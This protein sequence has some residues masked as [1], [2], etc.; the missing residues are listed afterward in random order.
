MLLRML[1]HYGITGEP[2]VGAKDRGLVID[3]VCALILLFLPCVC[4]WWSLIISLLFIRTLAYVC[5][6]VSLCRISSSIYFCIY[7]LLHMPW[8]ID[9]PLLVT[10]FLSCSLQFWLFKAYTA[11][12][13]SQEALTS[14]GL[15]S[16]SSL[17][18][19]WRA[20]PAEF[21]AQLISSFERMELTL[22]LR[23]V[24]A[25]AHTKR[26]Q[27]SNERGDMITDPPL[28]THTRT[29]HCISSVDTCQTITTI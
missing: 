5:V 8:S 16:E 10:Y 21:H 1:Y 4:W 15:V 14:G 23:S 24:R 2:S 27:C 26:S 19:L 22:P 12:T 18:S 9:G 28:H 20:Y 7:P 13:S 29:H 17:R 25:H 3:P 6:Y 11:L